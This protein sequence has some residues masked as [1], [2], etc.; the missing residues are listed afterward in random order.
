MPQTVCDTDGGVATD[1]E[2]KP[3]N[4]AMTI[5]ADCLHQQLHTSQPR[6]FNQGNAVNMAAHAS[7]SGTGHGPDP[8]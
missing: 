5:R 1:S 2:G 6:D 4:L 3:C 7:R 8:P